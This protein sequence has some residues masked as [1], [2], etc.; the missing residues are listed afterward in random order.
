MFSGC[1][2]S[3]W[4]TTFTID[5][6]ISAT[7]IIVPSPTAA[8]VGKSI[9]G[10]NKGSQIT[11]ISCTT[12]SFIG[13]GIFQGGQSFVLTATAVDQVTVISVSTLNPTLPTLLSLW[14]AGCQVNSQNVSS[15]T[16]TT[17]NISIRE[18][19]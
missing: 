4:G 10:L 9:T 3:N 15:A 7:A 1:T 2:I 13:N 16:A 11:T 18:I 6:N 12:G 14:T 17:T 19:A 8:D 5:N